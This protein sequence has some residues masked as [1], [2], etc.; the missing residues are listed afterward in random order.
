MRA[1]IIPIG[2]SRGI[3]I[4]KILLEQTGLGQEVELEVEDQKIVIR[5]P[6]RS[7]LGWEEK[8]KAMAEQGDDRLVEK[9]FL[10]ETQWD[11]E[12]WEW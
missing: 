11:R 10:I 6:S 8:F 3:R 7:R 2:N 1:Q 5:P 12:E 4:P 9:E